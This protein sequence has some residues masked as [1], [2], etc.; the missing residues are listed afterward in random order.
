[1]RN[2]TEHSDKKR[3]EQRLV[4]K[5]FKVLGVSPV[6]YYQ[7]VLSAIARCNEKAIGD[8]K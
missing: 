7:N 8:A 1:M 2:L 4:E 3:R 5:F 6:N